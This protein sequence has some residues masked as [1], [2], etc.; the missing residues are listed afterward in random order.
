M[1]L[2][3]TGR[4][5]IE[6]GARLLK[7]TELGSRQARLA[8]AYL[9]LERRRAVPHDELAEAIW[10]EGPPA[11]W[12]GD[13]RAI[14]SRLRRVLDPLATGLLPSALGCYQLSLPADAWVDVEA[15]AAAIHVAETLLRQGR[16]K[17]A[18]GWALVARMIGRRPLLPG[19]QAGWLEPTRARLRD[20]HV[21]ALEALAE[22]WVG[23]GDPL[24]G[25]R[26]AEEAV[27]LEPYRETAHQHLIRAH[28][29]AGNRGQ[30]V[31]AYQR[32]RDL[33]RR[34]LQAEPSPAT[35]AV[36][37][38]ATILQRAPSTVAVEAVSH[39]K[40]VPNGIEGDV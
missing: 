40:E 16:S 3:L 39:P 12:E 26:D 10:Q 30:A 14:I 8:F 22:I 2:Y 28:A 6:A 27:R 18:C 24:L 7:E 1:R 4:L 13:L 23:A 36:Y 21:R 15:A 17:P 34:E 33:L 32:C 35:E 19:Q 38:E 9:A 29:A 20:V 37:R 31:R 5:T 25:A 11:A